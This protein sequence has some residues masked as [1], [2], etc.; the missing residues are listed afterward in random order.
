MELLRSLVAKSLVSVVDHGQAVRYRLLESVRL[1][2]EQKLVES[3]E[4]QELRSGH[5][6]FYLQWIESLPLDQFGRALMLGTSQVVT[7]ADNLTGALEWSRQQGRYDH[8]ARIALRMTNYWF[9]FIRLAEMRAWWQEL[10]RGLPAGDGEAR[11]MAFVLRSYAAFLAGD[12]QETNE[13]SAR[14]SA[15]S[16]PESFVARVARYAQAN[17]WTVFDPPR[18]DRLFQR[19]F[20]IEASMGMAPIPPPYDAHY[21]S[22]L[23]RANGR[24][25]APALLYEWRAGLRDSA[26]S[27]AMAA[28]FA[29][30]SE[31]QTALELECRAEPQNAPMGRFWDELSQAVLASALK[32]FDEA[33]QHLATLASVVRDHA[34]PRGEAGCLVGFAK[35][36]LDR[37]DHARA[38]GLLA[39]VNASFRA[40]DTPFGSALDALIYVHCARVLGDVPD[41]YTARTT[42]AEGAALSLRE[43]LDA[44]LMRSATTTGANPTD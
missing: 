12:W 4:S 34:M 36:A 9:H 38:S 27:H 28:T 2:A 33:E 6:D 3:G 15:L 18:G 14:A 24:D 5:R 7:E 25:E 16:D 13:W 10:D 42:Q 1:Y 8:C 22:R 41:P 31:T 30:Y 17:Y 39:A 43:A 21:I 37:G 19:I 40:G 20:K 11:A 26:P 35:V 23:R 32:Q 44:E 29:L